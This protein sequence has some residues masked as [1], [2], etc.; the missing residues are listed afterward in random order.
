MAI[1]FFYIYIKIST[2]TKHILHIAEYKI[3]FQE[4]MTSTIPTFIQNSNAITFAHSTI[5]TFFN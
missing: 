2:N 3:I 1:C 5:S 4:L